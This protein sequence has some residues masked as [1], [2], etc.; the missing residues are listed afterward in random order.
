MANGLFDYNLVQQQAQPNTT[1]T[2][3]SIP[4]MSQG[5]TGMP[6]GMQ[7]GNLQQGILSQAQNPPVRQRGQGILS[8]IGSG[9]SG[10]ARSGN[11]WDTLAIGFS[12]MS[13]R[14]NQAIISAAQN[15][16][17]LRQQQQRNLQNINQTIDY[18]NSSDVNRPDLARLIQSIGTTEAAGVVFGQYMKDLFPEPVDVSTND[19]KNYQLMISQGELNP[20]EYT[21]QQF[22]QDKGTTRQITTS[23]GS[24]VELVGSEGNYISYDPNNPEQ[25]PQWGV[26][27]GSPADLSAQQSESEQEQEQRQEL[28]RALGNAQQSSFIINHIDG[29]K[30][31]ITE[32]S[33]DIFFG[34]RFKPILMSDI[35]MMTR[36]GSPAAIASSRINTLKANIGFD[37]LQAMREAS[38]TGGALGQVVVAELERLE[39]VFGSLDL[40]NLDEPEI[41]RNLDNIQNAYENILNNAVRA[42]QNPED[43][44]RNSGM[45]D[46]AISADL[47]MAQQIQAIFNSA[48]F[49]DQSTQTSSSAIQQELNRRLG[50]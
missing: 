38:P 35:A 7:M 41:I 6:S 8:T 34:G 31:Y 5:I 3:S 43:Y 47:Q 33:S 12:G 42:S 39:S 10:L 37:R 30:N 2:P 32:N 11:F 29:L 44:F 26:L 23:Q 50:R 49:M 27:E 13:M 40:A 24:V 14:P 4:Q 25:A 21:F 17:A 9:L 46:E 22:L 36:G 19:W 20:Q 45:S 28:N 16:M 18:F 1:M 48:Q 15:R